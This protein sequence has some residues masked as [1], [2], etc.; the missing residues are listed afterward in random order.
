MYD[1]GGLKAA[2]DAFEATLQE[3]SIMQDRDFENGRKAAIELRRKIAAHRAEVSS[4]LD[5]ALESTK[6]HYAFRTRFSAL[7][8]ALALHQANWPV[9]TI[10]LKNKAYL[11]SSADARAA[12]RGFFQWARFAF[13]EI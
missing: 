7:C 11:A 13:S 4:L 10:D 3:S 5:Q 2:L 1:I 8:F 9:V 12:Y 6:L